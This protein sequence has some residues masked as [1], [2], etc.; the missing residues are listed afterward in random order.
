MK[1]LICRI[2]LFCLVSI[3]FM[4]CSQNNPITPV[5]SIEILPVTEVYDLK[6][7]SYI[8]VNQ[9]I[10]STSTVL[11][12][13]VPGSTLLILDND[14]VGYIYPDS[15]TEVNNPDFMRAHYDTLGK[16]PKITCTNVSKIS[17]DRSNQTLMLWQAKVEKGIK[18]KTYTANLVI[19]HSNKTYTFYFRINVYTTKEGLLHLTPSYFDKALVVPK[20]N[21]SYRIRYILNVDYIPFSK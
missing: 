13:E 5:D 2:L 6:Q 18:N 17:Y 16:S 7:E 3:P 12:E 8:P 21:I 11:K 10:I 15:L 1:Q 9:A 20:L 14:S 19:N 4:G